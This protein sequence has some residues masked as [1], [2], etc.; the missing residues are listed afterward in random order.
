MG[1][2][3]RG[4]CRANA[5]SR[6]IRGYPAIL[7]SVR[8]GYSNP[9]G[10]GRYSSIS[11]RLGQG[12][13]HTSVFGEGAISRNPEH[14]YLLDRCREDAYSSPPRLCFAPE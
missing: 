14:N 3:G 12:C 1:R 8:L 11:A 13:W 10:T 4:P 7:G 9:I 2:I 5:G 6:L